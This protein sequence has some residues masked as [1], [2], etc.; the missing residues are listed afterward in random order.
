MKARFILDNEIYELTLSNEH[1]AASY[2]QP[3][4]V[5]SEGTAIDAFSWAFY[6]VVDATDDELDA[7]AVAGYVCSRFA[8]DAETEVG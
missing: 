3:V 4:A 2:G 8:Q 7:F 5:T 1:S 6:E